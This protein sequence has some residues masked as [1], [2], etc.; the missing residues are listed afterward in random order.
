MARSGSAGRGRANEGLEA[1]RAAVL[2]LLGLREVETVRTRIEC[3]D[4]GLMEVVGAARPRADARGGRPRIY[5]PERHARA[6]EAIGRLY[7]EA[8]GS[9][10][11]AFSGPV[12][13]A[14]VAH[15]HMP[16]S[17][18]R[19]REGEQDM[20]KPDFDNMAKL[21]ADALNGIA[22]RDDAQVVAAIAAKAPRRG[23][24]DWYEI[25]VTYCEAPR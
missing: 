3:T 16:Q 14:V 1:A 24:L 7:R 6:Q 2:G 8:H 18:P 20:G 17:W 19:H 12:L 11:G 15:R 4:P 23:E 5:M 10:R 21:V 22:W 25:E 13:L 9:L